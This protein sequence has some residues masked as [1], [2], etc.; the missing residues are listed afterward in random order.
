MSDDLSWSVRLLTNGFVVAYRIAE[1]IVRPPAS[2]RDK[3]RRTQP[4]ID[5]TNLPDSVTKKN[6]AP[7]SKGEATRS[8]TFTAKKVLSSKTAN[9]SPKTL[10]NG[11]A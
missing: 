10:K 7:T 9:A 6:K 5:H 2:T 1:P 3:G 8:A 4:S 11:L